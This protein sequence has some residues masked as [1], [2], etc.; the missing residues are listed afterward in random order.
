MS[1]EIVIELQP[2]PF[3]DK[4]FGVGPQLIHH[5]ASHDD[6]HTLPGQAQDSIPRQ[7]CGEAP[8]RTG[9]CFKCKQE[10][11]WASECPQNPRRRDWGEDLERLDIPGVSQAAILGAQ[12]PAPC[13][14]M[15]P[16]LI[17]LLKRCL[18]AQSSPMGYKALLSGHVDH[19]DAL[20]QDAGWGCGYKNVQMQLSHAVHSKQRGQEF[21]GPSPG[22]SLDI[23]PDIP[24]LQAW[25]ELAWLRGFDDAGAHHFNSS[26][27]GKKA[28][29][30]TPEC[31]AL[32]KYLG[33]RAHIVDFQTT[34]LANGGNPLAGYPAGASAQEIH[35]G[36]RCDG[37]N[38]V[39]I[40]GARHKSQVLPDY[41]LCSSCHSDELQAAASGPFKRIKIQGGAEVSAEAA[42]KMSWK[43][44]EWV[45]RY[46]DDTP[47]DQRGSLQLQPD[48]PVKITGK[49]PLY[50][51]HDGHSRTIVGIERKVKK[52]QGGGFEYTLLVLDP[53]TPSRALYS[54]L[55][56]NQKWQVLVRRGMHTLKKE[57]YQLLYI[58]KL[59]QTVEEYQ[60]LSNTSTGVDLK[61]LVTEAD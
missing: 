35:Q 27:Q 4:L 56:S 30:G 17:V 1:D 50:F 52:Q 33:L 9:A 53:A 55:Q 28:W 12:R 15:E 49:P 44:V 8:K 39:P 43:L 54:A 3:C 11:H 21:W 5:V 42:A 38:T 13:L 57:E 2:C 48:Q 7:D 22:V 60:R 29:I 10:G 51:Q 26:L 61:E 37:C 58:E 24:S 41:D 16:P 32:L 25:T 20:C 19:Y 59:P 18:L 40:V 31:G 14:K 36:V 47:S 6:P 34:R 46:F 45:W 23:V